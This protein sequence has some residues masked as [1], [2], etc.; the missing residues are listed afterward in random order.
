MKPGKL[1]RFKLPE[2]TPGWNRAGGLPPVQFIYKQGDR[3]IYTEINATLGIKGILFGWWY[4]IWWM[5]PWK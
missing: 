4:G 1:Y 3:G 5:L 2:P